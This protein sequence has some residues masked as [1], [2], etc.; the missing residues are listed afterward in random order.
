MLTPV[1]LTVIVRE[2]VAVHIE[3]RARMGEIKE[4]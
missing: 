4:G 2:D 1:R 3:L